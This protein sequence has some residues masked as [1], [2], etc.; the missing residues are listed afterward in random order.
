MR[1]N[2][3]RWLWGLIPIAMLSWIAFNWERSEIE[4]D[5]TRRTQDALGKAGLSWAKVRFTGRD[6][7][8]TGLAA[9]ESEPRRAF[10]ISKKVWGVRVIDT[11]TDLMKKVSEFSWLA[12]ADKGRI[13][14]SGYIPS[15]DVRKNVIEA[16]KSAFPK[17]AIRDE[18][19]LA[20]GTP[21][22]DILLGAI[23][24]GLKQLAQLNSGRIDLDGTALSIEGEASSA[25][26]YKS[27]MAALDGKMPK[28]IS[29]KSNSITPPFVRIFAWQAD[30]EK[31]QLTLGGHVP[32]E[33]VR[34]KLYGLAKKRFPAAAIVDRMETAAGAPDGWPKAASVAL[35]QLARLEYGAVS[36]KAAQL[37]ISG[38]AKDEATTDSIRK[39]LRSQVPATFKTTEK[40]EIRSE[41]AI[42]Y[43]ARWQ[44]AE[45]RWNEL[46]AK[47]P[48]PAAPVDDGVPWW[49]EAQSRLA[50]IEHGRPGINIELSFG[51]GGD[52]E[53]K[54]RAEEEARA[55]AEEE[56]ER[57]RR[58]EAE[59]AAKAA[60]E[61]RLRAEAEARNQAWV[62]L[63][64]RWGMLN[65]Q[66]QARRA[67]EE[68]ERV[69]AVAKAE[70]K[71]EVDRCQMRMTDTARQGRILFKSDSA[72]L[73]K[74][75]TPT[76]NKL[77][78]VAKACPRVVINIEGHTDSRG[79]ASMNM[80]L[81]ERRAQSI[82]DYL[83]KAG[84]EEGRLKAKGYGPTRPI[85]PNNSA[86]NMARN[87]RIEFTVIPN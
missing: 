57:T 85:A 74:K 55:R 65:E 15:E 54:K 26:A 16:A 60:E 62:N 12:K 11:R 18:M 17:F 7:V 41:P 58:L 83:V 66:Y 3:L 6:G 86:A 81:S 22:Q 24:F 40:I 53:A 44:E 77:A 37:V 46:E 68:E 8:L 20:R 72:A 64:L 49:K 79:N 80:K 38:L 1:C 71:A 61:E 45:S 35:E 28:G 87:R 59:R 9:E 10:D 36:T 75:S 63:E 4:S 78:E 29:L 69:T 47:R 50:E 32:S 76:L 13:S 25:T 70:R 21:P 67:K 43:E 34:E 14:L 51:Q 73:D 42:D 33:T 39:S 23:G 5:L 52:E 27:V 2:P 84:V 19:E 30:L 31:N 56:A 48:R 82:V